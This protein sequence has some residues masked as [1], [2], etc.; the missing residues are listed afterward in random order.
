MA[1]NRKLIARDFEYEKRAILDARSREKVAIK[2]KVARPG[3]W[4]RSAR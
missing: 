4:P 1:D 3:N 2:R